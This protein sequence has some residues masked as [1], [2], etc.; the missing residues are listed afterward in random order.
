MKKR[1]ILKY[2]NLDELKLDFNNPR[3]GELYNGSDKEDDLVEYLLYEEAA[4]EIAHAI[5]EKDEFYEDKALWVI[6]DKDGKYVVRDGNRRCAAVKALQM[7]GKYKLS[8]PKTPIVELPVYEYTDEA[9]LKARIGEEH[10]ASLFRSWERIAKALQILDLADNK[11]LELMNSLDP[12]PGD[13]IKLGTFYKEAV[14]Y[15]GD[16]LR[17]QLRKGRGKTGGKTIIYERLF[18]DAKI[19]G[20]Q[21]KKAPSSRIEVT[22]LEKFKS[23]IKALVK[24][25]EANPELKTKDID[26]DKS[27]IKKLKDYGFDAFAKLVEP[28]GGN[29][30]GGSTNTGAGTGSGTTTDGTGGSPVSGSSGTGTGSSGASG[31]SGTSGSGGKRGSVKKKATITRKKVPSGLIARIDEYF[32]IDSTTM[33]NAKIA[34]ARVTYECALKYVVDHT[35]SGRIIFKN[36]GHFGSAYSRSPF[37][38]FDEMNKKFIDLIKDIGKKQAFKN[39]EFDKMHAIIH[40]YNTTGQ[41]PVADQIKDNF[42]VLLE[43]ML[44]DES[45]L[46]NSLDL[47]KIT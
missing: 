41:T 32:A 28:S 1:S 42:I 3:F 17:K 20:Y 43:F 23:Y 8:D 2:L 21:F 14:K 22:D 33:P 36:S 27:F 38:N 11:E 16:T 5:V 34:M 19:C 26:D 12:R 13:Y 6:K 39:F 44:Q 7:P 25:I 31:A 9:E 29:G 18:R 45:D 46:L 30:T 24:Y 40:N 4:E 10:S 15:G 37:T 35:K 47:T